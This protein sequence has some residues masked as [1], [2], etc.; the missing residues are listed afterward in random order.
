MTDKLQKLLSNES[1]TGVV[2][3]SWED[4]LEPILL[5]QQRIMVSKENMCSPEEL[6]GFTSAYRVLESFVIKHR[7]QK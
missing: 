5:E 3:D 1:V 4:V 7:K 6:R 2:S